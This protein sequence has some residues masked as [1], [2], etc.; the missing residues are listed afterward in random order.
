MKICDDCGELKPCVKKDF[1]IDW[2]HLQWSVYGLIIPF[3]WQCKECSL[4]E[5]ILLKQKLSKQEIEL[6]RKKLKWRKQRDKLLK[7][8]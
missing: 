2:S 7:K 4:A 3:K 1:V 5:D 8:K 6:Q